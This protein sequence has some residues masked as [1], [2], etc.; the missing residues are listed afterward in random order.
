MLAYCANTVLGT[1][2]AY[3]KSAA[4]AIITA[5]VMTNMLLRFCIRSRCGRYICFNALRA[6]L[7]LFI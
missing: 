5:P 3:E 4:I 7:Q 1:F 2:M 6:K